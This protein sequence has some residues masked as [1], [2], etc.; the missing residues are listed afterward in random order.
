MRISNIVVLIAAVLA[1]TAHAGDNP[2]MANV[3][4]GTFAS[5]LPIAPGVSNV[6]VAQFKLDRVPVTNADYAQFVRQHPEWQRDR[7]A[8]IFADDGYLSHWISAGT[9]GK[10]VN[11]KPVIHISWF[12]ASA[13]CEARGAR[14][15]KW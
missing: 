12:A 4:T 8:R 1:S 7:V 10:D 9:P 13:Y 5:V 3:P 2:Q 6:S 15:P 14:L 11:N